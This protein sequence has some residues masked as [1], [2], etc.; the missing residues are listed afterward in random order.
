M[1]GRFY[2]LVGT[3]LN[4][5]IGVIAGLDF[6]YGPHPLIFDGILIAS[7]LTQ[8]LFYRLFGYD[9]YASHHV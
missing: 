2:G 1:K 6:L 7:L 9:Q 5:A 3:K 8:W 4:V